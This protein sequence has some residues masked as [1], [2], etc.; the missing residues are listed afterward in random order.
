MQETSF[1]RKSRFPLIYEIM[2]WLVYTAVYKYAYFVGLADLPNPDYDDFPHKQLLLFAVVLTLYVIPYYRWLAP[3][4]LAHRRYGRLALLTLAWFLIIPKFSNLAAGWLFMAANDHGI[5]Q[6][7]FEQRL[8]IYQV[9][10]V[11]LRG[12]NLQLILTD[13][14]AFGSVALTRYAFD[15]E[16][17]KRL[18]EKDIFHLQ[19]DALK[20]QLNPHFLFN[21]LNSIYGMSL[22]G[23]ADTPRYVLQLADMMRYILYDCRESRVPLEKDIAFTESY[24]AMEKTRYPGVDIRFSVTNHSKPGTLIAPLLLIPFVENSFKHGAH[25][26]IDGGYIHAELLAAD[27][28]LQFT[29]EN[30][31][32]ATTGLKREAGGI[33]IENVKKRLQLY[34]PSRHELKIENT[35]SVYKVTLTLFLKNNPA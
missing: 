30:D 24:V 10:A 3:R 29:V 32:F 23:S 13:L 25:R 12:W 22:T 28:T 1:N 4:L 7:F 15:N 5:Y 16:R 27:D 11:H 9:Q 18:L 19:L 8:R 34:Y 6:A 26:V 17:K 33:G 20:A 31:I 2:V 21:T 14:L 35:G